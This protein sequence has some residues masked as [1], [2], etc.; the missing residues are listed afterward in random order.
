MILIVETSASIC[1][2]CLASDKGVVVAE[3]NSQLENEHSEKLAVFVQEVLLEAGISIRELVAVAVSQGPGSYTGLRIGT[4]L[5]KGICFACNIPL[6]QVDALK[7]LA[8]LGAEMHSDADLVM[9]H[10]DAR[11]NE[12]YMQIW[13]INLDLIMPTTAVVI[14]E[15]SFV[16]WAKLKTVVIGNCPEKFSIFTS[17]EN[18][19]YMEFQMPLARHSVNEA[20]E[21]WEKREFENIAYYEPKYLKDFIPGIQKKSSL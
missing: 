2:V 3:R 19:L 21:K 15:N 13:G 10:L 16:D 17:W 6:I 18:P 5:A 7:G 4:S 12:V 14:D 11:R 9:S 20:I 8:I 1:S